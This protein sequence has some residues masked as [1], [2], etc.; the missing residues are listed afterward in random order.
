M[1]EKY[2]KK[3]VLL[4]DGA[5][6]KTSLVRR[7]VEQKFSDEYI[8]TIGANIKKKTINYEEKDT[9]LDMVI[10]DL[11]GQQGF[12]E[13]QKAN[14]KGA[15]GAF[16]VCDLTRPKTRESIKD[17]WLPLLKD[18]LGE[19]PAVIFLANKSDLVGMDTPDIKEYRSELLSLS[20]EYGTKFFFTSAK[21]GDNVEQSFKD[22]GLM[23]LDYEPQS[24]YNDDLYQVEEGISPTKALDLFKAQLYLE[25]GGEEFVNPILQNQ[26]PKLGI[27]MGE[28]PTVEQLKGFNEKIK[29][30][31]E[32]FIDEKQA[33]RLHLKRKSILSK[34][35]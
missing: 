4:G 13:T 27:D 16:V 23:T 25:L 32:D 35:E 6:G 22:L 5:V 29:E 20:E 19:I 14:M 28:E 26:L 10:G 7:Y 31:E 34:L 33:R 11:L 2:K 15:S 17:Y 21:T 12:Q 1:T 9:R 3:V 18:V 30:L 24:Y 8:K